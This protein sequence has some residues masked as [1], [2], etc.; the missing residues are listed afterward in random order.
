[1]VDMLGSRPGKS[2]DTATPLG[3]VIGLG[4]IIA[5]IVLTGELHSYLDLAGFLL[6]AGGTLAATLISAKIQSVIGALGVVKNAFLYPPG[7]PIATIETIVRLSTIARRDGILALEKEQIDDPFLAKALR[8]AVDGLPL[9]EIIETLSA[10]LVAMKHRHRRGQKL[11]RFMGTTAP[12]MGMIGTLIGLVQMLKT[13]SKPSEI[14]P[15]M[16]MALL[17]T[18]YGAVLAF[19]IFNPI[20]EKLERRSDEEIANMTVV[21]AGVESILKGQHALVIREKLEA[22][23]APKERAVDERDAA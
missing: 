1:M 6:V 19:L 5:S 8:K 2:V 18:M 13:M 7:D 12:S 4:L 3:I 21:M 11:F 14:G 22:H 20:A 10:E 17:A 16:A 23:L 15:A 9:E